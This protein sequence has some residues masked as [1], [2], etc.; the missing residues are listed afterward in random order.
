M[1]YLHTGHV[2]Q[3]SP[4]LYGRKKGKTQK[5]NWMSEELPSSID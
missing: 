5:I 2:S 4:V 1:E 3:C